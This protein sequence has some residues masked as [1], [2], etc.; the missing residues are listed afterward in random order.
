MSLLLFLSLESAPA[1]P[2]PVGFVPS[3]FE[4]LIEQVD[5]DV[6]AN[7][8]GAPIT[9]TPDGGAPVVITG[10]FD[11][12]YVLAKGDAESGVETLGPAVFVRL[13]DLPTDPEDDDP[14]ITI[15][16]VVYRVVERRPDGIG[17]IVL[18]LHLVT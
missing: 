4:A 7:L 10:I 18:A 9:Y 16:G 8:G 5:L 3:P 12:R 17:G 2:V 15:S 14:T 1:L 13:S 6:F 11:A